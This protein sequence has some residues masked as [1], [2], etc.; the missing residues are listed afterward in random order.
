MLLGVGIFSAITQF[1]VVQAYRYAVASTV[2]AFDYMAVIYAALL[3]MI[4]L[5]EIPSWSLVAGG[6]V[7]VICGVYI[8][9]D[10]SRS[11]MD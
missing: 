6:T 9:Y 10:E 2:I 5:G 1:L 4:I 8:V 3:G 11:G 7:L